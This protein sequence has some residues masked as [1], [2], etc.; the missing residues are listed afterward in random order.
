[1]IAS[2][3]SIRFRLLRSLF[4][5]G[6][7]LRGRTPASRPRRSSQPRRSRSWRSSTTATID[8]QFAIMLATNARVGSGFPFVGDPFQLPQALPEPCR[9][10]ASRSLHEAETLRNRYD[11]YLRAIADMALAV[12]ADVRIRSIRSLRASR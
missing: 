9:S 3:L 12:P 2:E 7:I 1:M 8:Y 10:S 4:T 11:T 5:G 6:A